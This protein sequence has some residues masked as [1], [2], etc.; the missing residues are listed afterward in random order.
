MFLPFMH[1]VMRS[2]ALS[3]VA[4]NDP[5][6]EHV[7]QSLEHL[8]LHVN[9]FQVWVFIK[10]SCTFLK[11]SSCRYEFKFLLSKVSGSGLLV[12]WVNRG[13]FL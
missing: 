11:K 2:T 8:S 7:S 12:Y 10:L 13:K 9:C 4:V 6:N 1:D 5:L 3:G